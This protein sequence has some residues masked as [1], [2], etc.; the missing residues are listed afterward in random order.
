MP[1]HTN[2]APVR[3]CDKPFI[4]DNFQ[5]HPHSF[6][7]EL[8][9]QIGQDQRLTSIPSLRHFDTARHN[10]K[11]IFSNFF[12]HFNYGEAFGDGIQKMREQLSCLWRCVARAGEV[13]AHSEEDRGQSNDILDKVGEVHMRVLGENQDLEQGFC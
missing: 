1:S 12:T 11:L 4:I 10:I 3:K 9:F 6:N 2:T 13:L 5:Y 7:Q 8:Q